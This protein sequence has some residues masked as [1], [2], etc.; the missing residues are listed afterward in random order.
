LWEVV[1]GIFVSRGIIKSNIPNEGFFA[2]ELDRLA[3]TLIQ[4][5]R[6]IFI[7]QL[8][9]NSESLLIPPVKP[10]NPLISNWLNQLRGKSERELNQLCYSWYIQD[11]GAPTDALCCP[12]TLKQAQVDERFEPVDDLKLYNPEADHGFMQKVPSPSG[13]AQRC[14]YRNGT[15]LVGTP[16]GGNV[17]SVSPNGKQGEMAHIIAD[18]LPWYTCCKLSVTKSYCDLYYE[19]RPSNNGKCYDRPG[20]GHVV[21]DPHFTT[22]DGFYYT[23]LGLGEF[24]IIQSR[25]F[26]MQGRFTQW[27][28]TKATV[29]TVYVM[30][31]RNYDG[32]ATVQ[33]TL[34]D[35]YIEVM[36]DGQ[37]VAMDPNDLSTKRTIMYNGVSIIIVSPKDI[38]VS[39][40]S[41]YS[42]KFT[43]DPTL[44]I[45]MA[46]VV[47]EKL[48]GT[49]RGLFGIFDDNQENELSYPN[50]KVISTN[51]DAKTIHDF[52]MSWK[53]TCEESHF[54]YPLG[55]GYADYQNDNFVPQLEIDMDKL[56]PEDIEACKGSYEC[57]FDLSVT[58]N[59]EMAAGT[60]KAVEDFSSMSNSL[61]LNVRCDRL[62]APSDGYL[63]VLNYFEGS[64]VRLVCNANYKVQGLSSVKCVKGFLGRLSWDGKLGTC[65]KINKCAN[66][67]SWLQWLC[68]NGLTS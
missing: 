57:L 67:N 59:K 28:D 50:G 47:A 37:I 17:R 29:C 48:K 64:T 19:K 6:N 42:F 8:K 40:S 35:N 18:I 33:L 58:G 63:L 60:L 56:S 9:I 61:S 52:G 11:K 49:F 36:I 12:Q 65:V 55:K 54:T 16:S 53:I 34:K 68:E 10:Q 30:H 20:C 5:L 46:S 31:Q 44:V 21:G 23:F 39:F 51:S 66:E 27:K 4:N 32:E 62:S 41:G 38:R 22:F 3:I 45:N 7:V 13:A 15:L 1:G 24:W 43:Y 25:D 2:G 14:V 26:E